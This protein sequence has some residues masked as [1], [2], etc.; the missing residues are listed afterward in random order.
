MCLIFLH[1]L[2]AQTQASFVLGCLFKVAYVVNGPGRQKCL[3]VEQRAALYAVQNSKEK[4]YF[5]V[6]IRQTYCLL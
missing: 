1:V 2:P 3:P 6:K 5:W 4:I